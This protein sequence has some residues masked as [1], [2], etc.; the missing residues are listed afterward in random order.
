MMNKVYGERL[1]RS[2]R[3]IIDDDVDKDGVGWG[4]FL[5]FKIWVEITK[6]LV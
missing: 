5:C 4:V 2:I 3:E 1:G 6:P